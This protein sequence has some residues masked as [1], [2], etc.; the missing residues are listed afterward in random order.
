[1]II[2]K[3]RCEKTLETIGPQNDTKSIQGYLYNGGGGGWNL[4]SLDVSKI[5]TT[6]KSNQNISQEL[7][8][9]WR[10]L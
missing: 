5:K 10:K 6:D 7:W 9:H 1:M 3:T 2:G 4:T 8:V